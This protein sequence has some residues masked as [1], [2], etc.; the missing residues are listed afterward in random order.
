MTTIDNSTGLAVYRDVNTILTSYREDEH[1]LSDSLAM[2]NAIAQAANAL[3]KAIKARR[4]D[5]AQGICARLREYSDKSKGLA[6]HLAIV[7]TR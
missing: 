4:Y 6:K 3:T 1:A 7:G 2:A 5:E